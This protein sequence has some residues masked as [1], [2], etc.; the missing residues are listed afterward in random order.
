MYMMNLEE[1]PVGSRVAVIREPIDPIDPFDTRITLV[2]HA[3]EE[4]LPKGEDLSVTLARK[5]LVKPSRYYMPDS[6]ST[7]VVDRLSVSEFVELARSDVSKVPTEFRDA[8]KKVIDAYE[9]SYRDGTGIV[10]ACKNSHRAK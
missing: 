1:F 8:W 3:N 9:S 6:T 10:A 7:R 5:G 4:G 2:Y